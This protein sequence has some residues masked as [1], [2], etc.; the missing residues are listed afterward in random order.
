MMMDV[1]PKFLNE[2]TVP[3]ELRRNFCHVVSYK[4]KKRVPILVVVTK[5]LMYLFGFQSVIGGLDIYLIF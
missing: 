2:F 3:E 4:K 5:M 1:L